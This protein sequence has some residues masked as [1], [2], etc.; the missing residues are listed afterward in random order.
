MHFYDDQYMN[1]IDAINLKKLIVC[2][3][4]LDN[5]MINIAV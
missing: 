1:F 2:F 3:N 5:K 4:I